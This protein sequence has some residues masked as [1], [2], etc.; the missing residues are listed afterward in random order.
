M[1]QTSLNVSLPKSLKEHVEQQV[2]EGGYSTPSEYVRE[3]L[4]D[5][6]RQKAEQKL[7]AMLLKGLRSGKPIPA[8]SAFWKA[9]RLRF[10]VEIPTPDELQAIRRGE[11]AIRRGDSITLDELRREEALA[12]RPRRARAKIA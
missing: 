7:E 8:D 12:H 9:K 10:P 1:E 6:K 4:R 11:A 3:L 5:D 2:K